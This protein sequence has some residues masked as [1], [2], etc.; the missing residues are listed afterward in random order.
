MPAA[1]RD[2]R[3]PPKRRT[4]V[5]CMTIAAAAGLFVPMILWL[6]SVTPPLSLLISTAPPKSHSST[7]A[8]ETGATAASRFLSMPPALADEHDMEHA[9]DPPPVREALPPYMPPDEKFQPP[10]ARATLLQKLSGH[11]RGR[12][13]VYP[14]GY[15]ALCLTVR[16]QAADMAE[17]LEWHQLIGVDRVYLFDMGSS[18]PMNESLQPYI[19]LGLVDYHWVNK[20]ALLALDED[21]PD[22]RP[23]QLAIYDVC[24]REFRHRH[25]WMGFFDAD[26]FVLLRNRSVNLPTFL[27]AYEQ[28]GGLA[29][30][31]DFFGSSGY[32]TRPPGG[33]LKSYWKCLSRD[34]PNARH[35]KVLVNLRF[36]HRPYLDPHTFTYT[37]NRRTVNERFAFVDGPMHDYHSSQK[38][39]LHHYFC[40]SLEEYKGKMKRGNAMLTSKGRKFFDGINTQATEE[41][42][43]GVNATRELGFW[44][45]KPEARP[46]PGGGPAAQPRGLSVPS[47][48][49]Q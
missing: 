40:K 36:A 35:V 26:E 29:L 39:V 8:A 43:D 2:D 17:W 10:V 16:D 12:R 31:W 28:H 37:R 14:E 6:T 13:Q 44:P 23:P 41:C 47:R 11:V 19:R 4:C 45:D 38:I 49:Q 32:R 34:H 30:S 25:A 42:W 46:Q 33:A 20:S 3:L 22:K 1:S 48:R 9:N 18:P 7:K 5:V 15:V 21:E 24:L 27:E